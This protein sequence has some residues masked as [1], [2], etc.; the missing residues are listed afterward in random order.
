VVSGVLS[1]QECNEDPLAKFHYDWNSTHLIL[2][3]QI[4]KKNNTFSIAITFIF[5]EAFWFILVLTE[6]IWRWWSYHLYKPS[7]GVERR[8]KTI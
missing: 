5:S 4:C 8:V 2:K 1:F 6:E 7:Q 3:M